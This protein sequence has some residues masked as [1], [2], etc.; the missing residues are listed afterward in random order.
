MVPQAESNDQEQKA[1]DV[2]ALGNS[3][4]DGKDQSQIDDQGTLLPSKQK[5]S[6]K[7][8][9]ALRDQAASG[10]TSFTEELKT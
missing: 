1:K 10:T 3:D 5:I 4:L 9:A 6:I 2:I 8:S 7:S